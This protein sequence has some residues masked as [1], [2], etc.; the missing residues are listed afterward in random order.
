[1]K[2]LLEALEESAQYRPDVVLFDR[3]GASFPIKQLISMLKRGKVTPK[4]ATKKKQ[5]FG[6]M[7]ADG[8]V[9]IA[10]SVPKIGSVAILL[11]GEPPQKGPPHVA[12]DFE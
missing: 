5:Y 12:L 3:E 8:K 9:T 11:E 4:A 2:T 10:R 1:M 7:T 6:G